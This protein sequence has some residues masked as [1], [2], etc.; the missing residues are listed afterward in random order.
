[1]IFVYFLFLKMTMFN[2]LN[3][4]LLQKEF[5]VAAE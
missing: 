3:P 4:I 5:Q 2:L 1:M